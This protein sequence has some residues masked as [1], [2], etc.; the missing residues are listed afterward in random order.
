MITDGPPHLSLFKDPPWIIHVC[1][2]TYDD[3]HDVVDA[4]P[5]IQ[6]IIERSRNQQETTTFLSAYNRLKPTLLERRLSETK[7][8]TLYV[9]SL[10]LRL[11]AFAIGGSREEHLL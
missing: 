4:S 1:Y 5:K 10:V 9:N 8:P 7:S 6:K 2:V 11:V 3:Y